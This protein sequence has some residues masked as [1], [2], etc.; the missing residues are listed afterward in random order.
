MKSTWPRTELLDA[1][2]RVEPGTD[3]LAGARAVV[4]L[5]PFAAPGVARSPSAR[6]LVAIVSEADELPV[7]RERDG[8]EAGALARADVRS[9]AWLA[10]VGAPLIAAARELACLVGNEEGEAEKA[11]S[12]D[13][14][15]GRPA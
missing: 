2:K 3:L 5:L 13:S 4:Q 14:S 15:S 7:G 10:K 11:Q 9:A 12:L 6:V 1:L 8:W